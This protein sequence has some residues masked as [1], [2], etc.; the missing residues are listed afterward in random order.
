LCLVLR[1]LN[2]SALGVEIIG[3]VVFSVDDGEGW[4]AGGER[5]RS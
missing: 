1:N 5:R 2:F 4:R 3:G